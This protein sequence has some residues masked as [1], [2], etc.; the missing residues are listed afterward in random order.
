M[1]GAALAAGGFEGIGN[2]VGPQVIGGRPADR[3]A[4][5]MSMTVA[6]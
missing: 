2:Q 5:A 4:E 1:G 3:A 6:R